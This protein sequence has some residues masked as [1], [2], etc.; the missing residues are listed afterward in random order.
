MFLA[1]T[2]A[3][4]QRANHVFQINVLGLKISTGERQTSLPYKHDRGVELGSIE[5]Q[6]EL[7]DY[8]SA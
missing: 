1:K 8:S 2:I 3:S 7:S 6:L 5:K 4:P